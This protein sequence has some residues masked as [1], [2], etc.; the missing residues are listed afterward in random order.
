MPMVKDWAVGQAFLMAADIQERA[1]A[2]RKLMAEDLGVARSDP[3]MDGVRDAETAAVAI[4]VELSR[5]FDPA[6]V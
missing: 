5:L 6:Y 2:L 3:A 4:G 1:A